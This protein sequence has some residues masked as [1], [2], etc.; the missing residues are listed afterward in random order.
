[1]KVLGIFLTS[2]AVSQGA[3]FWFDLLNRFIT[4]RSTVKPREKSAE[5]PSKDRPVSVENSIR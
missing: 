4:I 2:L 1:L 3:P 5:Q